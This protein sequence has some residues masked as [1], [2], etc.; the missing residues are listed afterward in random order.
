MAPIAQPVMDSGRR[1]DILSGTPRAHP[2]DRWIFVFMAGWF[3]AIVLA[4]FIPS[5]LAKIAAV[6]AGQRPPFPW[7][8]HVHAILMGSFLLLLLAQTSL[9]ATGRVQQH[10]RLGLAA[11]VIA[12]ALVIAGFLLVRGTYVGLAGA[13][14][15][16]APAAK[17][18]LQQVVLHVDNIMLLQI[19]IGLLFP[20]FLFIGLRA[21]GADAGMH[22]RMMF[23]ATAMALPAG[24]D[25]IPWL[26]TTLPGSPLGPD[27]YTLVAVLPMFAWDL[28]RNRRVH[29]AYW[30]WLAVNLPFAIA[31]HGLWGTEW[32][33]DAAPRLMGVG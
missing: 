29:P 8:L 18:E 30:I 28:A 23:L 26:P 3:I 24:I 2:I 33:H 6:E 15:A 21:R 12:P 32:W 10:R 11:M 22:K 5:S 17:A 19:R 7:I 27:F 14:A 16:A 9:M 20:V 13:L 4:G 25:R 31:V 1:P